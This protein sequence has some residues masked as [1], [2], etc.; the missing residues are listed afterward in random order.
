MTK[1]RIFL[2]TALLIGTIFTSCEIIEAP[3][4]EL[5]PSGCIADEACLQ[6]APNPND[7]F[8]GVVIEKKV[9]LE[10]FTG[11]TCGRCPA[12]TE[13]AVELRDATYKDRMILLSVHAGALSEPK[14]IGDKYMTDFRTAEGDEL[15]GFFFPI[16]AVPFGLI[17][18]TK[19]EPDLYLY[20]H[21]KWETAVGEELARP[22]EAGIIITNCYD[23]STREAVTIVDVKYLVAATDQE[24]LSVYLVEDEVVDWQTDYRLPDDE[25]D[26][27][28]YPHHEV[29]RASLNGTWGQ[30]LSENPV[31]KDATFRFTFCHQIA[32]AQNVAH[33]RVVAFVHN[34][35]TKEIRQ[36]EVANVE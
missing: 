35:G 12:A 1:H 34:F 30:R 29:L 21:F 23:E 3:Y 18:R 22:A 6:A 16:N 31:P 2:L 10:E 4:V 25:Q 7:P 13:V 36:V 8:M 24:Y 17:N 11:H 28:D 14:T 27:I 33:S 5:P 15:F 9:L 32:P 26:I 19:S 20:D